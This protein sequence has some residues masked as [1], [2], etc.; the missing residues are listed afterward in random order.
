LD[1]SRNLRS[2]PGDTTKVRRKPALPLRR[3]PSGRFAERVIRWQLQHG[4]HGLPW[5][6]SRDPYAIWVSEIMLQQTQVAAVIP[7][8][9]RFM[10]AFADM[11]ALARAGPEEVMR[12]WSGLGYYSRA[13]NLHAAAQILVARYGAVF[14]R[15]PQ[16]IASL[17]GVGR[18]TA[19]A[20][21]AL[22][23]GVR[24]AILDGNVK[25]VLCRA[26]AIEGDP[27]SA[28]TQKRLWALA[29]ALLPARNVEAYTQGL[30]DLGATVCLRRAPK[31]A[32]CPVRAV[33][34]AAKEGRVDELP[35]ARAR[36][37]RPERSVAMLILQHAARVLLVKRP[38]AGI[39]GG[40]WCFP[41]AQLEEDLAAICARRFGAYGVRATALP[42][43]EHGFTHFRLRIH[44]LR[45]DIAEISGQAAEPGSVWLA[46]DEA[47]SAAIPAPVRRLLAVS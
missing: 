22:A 14:P 3:A 43:F 31:C 44:P 1:T 17:P 8:Y 10:A 4:R 29:E 5:Q 42:P 2:L 41:E 12:H 25:R 16:M 26:F 15:D 27:G 9:E 47:R 6:R 34:V 46:L 24:A 35:N 28:A 36:R 45:I 39:W 37:P 18:S 7:Y 30:M 19:A 38:P 13:R 21:A 20:I 32:A 11:S 33:C 40:L 23:Y